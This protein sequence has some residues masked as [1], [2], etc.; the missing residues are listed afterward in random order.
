MVFTGRTCIFLDGEN[1][2]IRNKNASKD[3]NFTKSISS[4]KNKVIMLITVD[5]AQG[6]LI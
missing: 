1:V 3:G 2:K 4:I 6:N 5:A